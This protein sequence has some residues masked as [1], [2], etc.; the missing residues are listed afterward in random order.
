MAFVHGK[1][2]LVFIDKFDLTRYFRE[3]N[4][5]AVISTADST[6]FGTNSKE[7]IV[8]TE[9]GTATLNGLFESTLL[10]GAKQLFDSILGGDTKSRVII[11]QFGHSLGARVMCLMA[12][13]SSYNV[14]SPIGDVVK[15]DASFIASEGVDDGVL[16][17]N[18]ASISAT[19]VGTGV[20]NTLA[21]ANGGVGFLSVPVDTRNGTIIV[22]IQ[23]SSDNAI[24]ADLVTFTTVVASTPTSE[25][26]VVA[27]GTTVSRYLRVSYT[28]AGS[29]GAATPVVAFARR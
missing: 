11:A 3:A 17:S 13:T 29:T 23:H 8:G 16:V 2:T 18:G 14:T 6:T 27:E 9:E 4:A 20:D 12:D 26:I 1:K 28:V 24:F 5:N 10:V 7:H 22:K 19:G 25:R 21:T 15:S